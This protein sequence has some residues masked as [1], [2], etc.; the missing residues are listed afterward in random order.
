MKK[1]A[2]L[3]AA[4]V[5]AFSVFPIGGASASCHQLV[6]GGRCIESVICGA[7]GVVN[8]HAECIQ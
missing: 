2:A 1:R 7:V 4:I 3:V 6:E 5:A 8:E